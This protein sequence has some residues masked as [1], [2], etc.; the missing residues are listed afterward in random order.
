MTTMDKVNAGVNKVYN[1]LFDKEPL[2]NLETTTLF[3]LIF[4]GRQNIAALQVLY[5]HAYD[6][7]LK[8]IIKE[9]HDNQTTWLVDHAEKL[10]EKNK[11]SSPSLS[12]PC[13]NL[14]QSNLDI[15]QDARFSDHEIVLVLS[16]MAKA[17]QMAILAA[18]HQTYQVDVATMYRNVLESAFDFNYR[19]LQLALKKGWL[20]TFPK[21]E[22]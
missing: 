18:M 12:L 10:L 21:I 16:N 8:A 1:A 17:S 2:N 19:L 13:H 9:A 4:A 6:N 20:P 11:T 15:P 3:T 22:H 14:H 5:N 7:D